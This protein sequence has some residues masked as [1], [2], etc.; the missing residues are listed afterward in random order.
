MSIGVNKSRRVFLSGAGV[1]LV[2]PFLPSAI[3]SRGRRQRAAATGAPRRFMAWF[4]PN[5]MVMPNW[6]PS[7]GRRRRRGPPPRARRSQPPRRRRTRRRRSG[8]SSI[9]YPLVA[10]G[11]NQ[12]TVVI[13]GLDHQ[14]IAIPTPACSTDT[15]PGGHGSGTG[16]FLNMVGVNCESTST[17]TARAWTSSSCRFSMPAET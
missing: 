11:L 3:W 8:S 10:A 6:T 9:L 7:V 14:N 2:L 12:K 1:T 5:G 13:S 16:C 4:N 17:R 15:V